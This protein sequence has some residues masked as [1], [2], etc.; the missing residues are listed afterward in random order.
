MVEVI[1]DT[2]RQERLDTF[3]KK[4]KKGDVYCFSIVRLVGN[5]AV[6]GR[7]YS[8]GY[9]NVSCNPDSQ[10]CFVISIRDV[11]SWSPNSIVIYSECSEDMENYDHYIE[12]AKTLIELKRED[13]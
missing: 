6:D 2:L 5:M 8:A 10:H 4:L 3:L 9:P 13:Y 7:Y 11:L 1:T 12:R